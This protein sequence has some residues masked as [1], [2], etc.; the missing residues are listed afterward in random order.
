MCA[1]EQFKLINAAYRT[2][3]DPVERHTYD[4]THSF[5]GMS[6]WR[7]ESRRRQGPREAAY[8]TY[9]PK[10]DFA[11]SAANFDFEEWNRMHFGPSANERERM[12]K[13][14]LERAAFRSRMMGGAGSRGPQKRTKAHAAAPGEFASRGLS[15]TDYFRTTAA[16]HRMMERQ[17]AKAMPKWLTAGALVAI[18]VYI[19]ARNVNPRL[20]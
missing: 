8:G 13:E 12:M 15:E 10:T 2:L 3:S 18:A 19:S 5:A 6:D 11:D 1:Q 9:N 4:L 20:D 16:E 17:T 14:Q 7:Q